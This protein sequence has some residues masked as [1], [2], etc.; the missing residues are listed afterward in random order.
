MPQRLEPPDQISSAHVELHDPAGRTGLLLKLHR[1][2]TDDDLALELTN[3]SAIALAKGK[4]EREEIRT[5]LFSN[6]DHA[7]GSDGLG[8]RFEARTGRVWLS[9]SEFGSASLLFLRRW[10][11]QEA[12]AKAYASCPVLS[13]SAD[14]NKAPLH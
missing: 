14:A 6:V 8:L 12:L 4:A 5:L 1:H 10:E 13:A 2:P 3:E 11:L 7:L 9:S